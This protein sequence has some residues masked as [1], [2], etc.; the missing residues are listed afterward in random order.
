MQTTMYIYT[1]YSIK[2]HRAVVGG[3][4]VLQ[5]ALQGIHVAAAATEVQRMG[6]DISGG[7]AVHIG[8]GAANGL[9]RAENGCK[10]IYRIA[11]KVRP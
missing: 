5:D 7:A 10:A 1:E 8:N 6:D 11:G 3:A 4:G 9:Q 2:N